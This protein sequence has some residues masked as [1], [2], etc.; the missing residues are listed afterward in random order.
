MQIKKSKKN[1]WFLFIILSCLFTVLGN[2]SHNFLYFLAAFL[3]GIVA[4]SMALKK[5]L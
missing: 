3:F 4:L 2:L 1:Y 5:E